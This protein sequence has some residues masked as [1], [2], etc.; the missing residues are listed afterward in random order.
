[1]PGSSVLSNDDTIGDDGTRVSSD[2]NQFGWSK[3]HERG[4]C[5]PINVDRVPRGRM[6]GNLA[7]SFYSDPQ[8]SKAN[9]SSIRD[10]L[11]SSNLTEST[12]LPG[13]SVLCHYDTFGDE[14]T[15][16][17]SERNRFGWSKQHDRAPC[18]PINMDRVPR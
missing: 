9:N 5:L 3:Q 7:P 8:L 16:L 15:R 13:S 14:G 12:L 4:P 6:R 18:P 1:M 2:R 17:S 10:R 11:S